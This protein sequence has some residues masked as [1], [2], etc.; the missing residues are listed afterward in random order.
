MTAP[1]RVLIV[2][3]D[4]DIREILGLILGADGFDV[5]VAADGAEA[6]QLL[7]EDPAI[8]LAI[9]DLMMPRM[10][11]AE[12]IRHLQ[13]SAGLCDLPVVILSGDTRC[14]DVAHELGDVACLSKPVDLTLLTALV[15]RTLTRA[16]GIRRAQVGS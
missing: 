14:T 10:S 11:G 6:L 5:R 7:S 15:W 3:D 4:P 8:A 9:V 16:E 13:G 12:L 1:P 2:D